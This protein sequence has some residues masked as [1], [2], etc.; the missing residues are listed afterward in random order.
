[1]SLTPPQLLPAQNQR[2]HELLSWLTLSECQLLSPLQGALPSPW[3]TPPLSNLVN[4]LPCPPSW[5]LGVSSTL[6]VLTVEAPE[7]CPLY[8]P[9]TSR[10]TSPRRPLAYTPGS[11]QVPVWYPPQERPTHGYIYVTGSRCWCPPCPKPA[12]PTASYSG[13]GSWMR[14]RGQSFM[15]TH[16]GKSALERAVCCRQQHEFLQRL[17]VLN[18]KARHGCWE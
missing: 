18:L 9:I 6:S 5:S 10:W 15:R 2:C 13:Q 7:E 14:E 17:S 16:Q 3:A 12:L 1:M 11:S 4:T 8:T